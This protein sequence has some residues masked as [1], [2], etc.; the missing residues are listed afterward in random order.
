MK[1][2]SRAQLNAGMA[3]AFSR[4]ALKN[5]ERNTSSASLATQLASVKARK[6]SMSVLSNSSD[7]NGWGVGWVGEVDGVDS[8]GGEKRRVDGNVDVSRAGPEKE[9]L[10]VMPGDGWT[11]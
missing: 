5:A 6:V 8:V 4:R 11:G 7:D 2:L 1:P 3:K 9:F 10:R